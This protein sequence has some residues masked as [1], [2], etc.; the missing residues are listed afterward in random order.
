MANTYEV[1][2]QSKVTGGRHNLGLFDSVSERGA[3]IKAKKTFDQYH[4]FSATKQAIVYKP[5]GGWA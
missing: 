5:E 3:K 2:G 4:D 1:Y